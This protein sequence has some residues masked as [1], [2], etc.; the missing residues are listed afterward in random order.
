MKCNKYVDA[1]EFT[2]NGGL[3]DAC[4]G[5]LSQQ[6]FVINGKDLWRIRDVLGKAIKSDLFSPEATTTLNSL[7]T[8]AVPL[9]I[10][11]YTSND[12]EED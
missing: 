3:C 6:E 12:N 11:L 4:V 8:D 1:T 2:L 9:I 5:F 7:K 10:R